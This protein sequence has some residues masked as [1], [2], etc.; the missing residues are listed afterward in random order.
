MKIT[1]NSKQL[2]DWDKQQLVISN[3][4]NTIVLTTT[5]ND[6]LYFRGVSI[7]KNPETTSW[8]KSE[9]KVFNGSISN[10]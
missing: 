3:L 7:E 4:T 6:E 5:E 10:D 2:I 9:F 8:L 1:D